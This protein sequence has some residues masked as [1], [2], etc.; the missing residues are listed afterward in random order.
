MDVFIVIIQE[1]I[2]GCYLSELPLQ[3]SSNEYPQH[4]LWRNTDIY[5]SVLSNALFICFLFA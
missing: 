1:N 3:G 2:A 5:A 4:M